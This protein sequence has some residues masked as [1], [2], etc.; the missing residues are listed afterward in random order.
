M[1]KELPGAKGDDDAELPLTGES[2]GEL[3]SLANGGTVLPN[4]RVY[5]EFR[6]TFHM[7]PSV[8]SLLHC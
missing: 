8:S 5:G 1:F 2:T 4:G 3:N 7:F 6:V